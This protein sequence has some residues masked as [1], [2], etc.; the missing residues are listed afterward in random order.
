M[1][2]S[3]CLFGKGDL[4]SRDYLVAAL[5]GLYGQCT[6]VPAPFWACLREFGSLDISGTCLCFF[7]ML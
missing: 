4:A 2:L 7:Q 6:S 1:V 5:E 3:K